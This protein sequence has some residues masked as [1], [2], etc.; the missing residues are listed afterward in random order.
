[1]AVESGQS[2]GV[3]DALAY[4]LRRLHENW[5]ALLYPRQ[6][7]SEHDVLGK[8]TPHTRHGWIAYRT[9]W[10]I[11][12]PIIALLYPLALTGF[13]TRYYARRIDS[14]AAGLGLVGV[15]AVTALV[16]GALTVLAHFQ[17][18]TTG[19]LA[20][21][22]AAIVATCSAGAA[23][24]FAGVGGRATTVVLAYPAATNAL[25][26]PPVVA[27]LFS[28]TLASMI[29]PGSY[30]LAVW[31]LDN[32]LVVAGLNETL[33]ANYTLEG[34]AYVAMWFGIAVPVGWLLGLVVTVADLARPT[35]R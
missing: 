31:L 1:M 8:W 25:F 23:Y 26:L 24:V 19:F 18:S 9:W 14:V 16:W 22:G 12:A 35:D 21:G 4:D 17:F 10:L 33:R 7:E 5:M 28:P 2:G 15:L 34:A 13:V 27:A 32:V 3:L 20:V 30:T 29:F 6:R 11:G